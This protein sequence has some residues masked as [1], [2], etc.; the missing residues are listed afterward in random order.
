MLNRISQRA[1]MDG[2]M[3]RLKLS[4]FEVDIHNEVSRLGRKLN[5]RDL[6]DFNSVKLTT[7]TRSPEKKKRNV[8]H[9]LLVTQQILVGS[10]S[11]LEVLLFA[12]ICFEKQIV[13]CSLP[14]EGFH[15]PFREVNYCCI[16][17]VGLAKDILKTS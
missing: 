5:L 7:S 1:A 11:L 3:F 4:S 8:R 15:V 13:P 6:S 14:W 9:Q 2:Q 16:Y 12:K 17:S 10:A